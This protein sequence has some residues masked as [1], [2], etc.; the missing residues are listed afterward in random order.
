VDGFGRAAVV[1]RLAALEDAGRLGSEQVQLAA[2]TLEV[3][4]R[5]VWRWVRQ[6][7]AGEGLSRR[8]RERFQV[9]DEIRQR[10]AFW[11]G[12]TAAVHRV[13][14][15]AAKAGGP[16]AP[17]LSTLQRAVAR[18]VLAGDRA[19][20]AAG[21]RARR[22][23]DV[24]LQRPGT[25]RNAGW[26]ADDVEV[27]VEVDAGGRLVKPWV[28]W[29]V[30]AGTNAVCGTAVTPG[31]PSRES[32]LAALR[33]AATMDAPYGPPGGLPE[34]VRIDR[35]KDFLSKTVTAAQAAA[36]LADAGDTTLQAEARPRLMPLRP[37]A[38][39]W[40]LPRTPTRPPAASRAECTD[41]GRAP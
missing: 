35:G 14:A 6:A 22:A 13:L 30:D 21:E 5:T 32:I 41:E 27:P 34:H 36:E 8:P 29:F 16:P 28:T 39:G 4:E 26:E 1:R 2:R 40:V 31:A 10:L 33:A 20:L 9:T 3:S 25:H 37:P 19:G 18:D 23:Y 17:S 38:P 12:N 15:A 11:R 24:F 7:R